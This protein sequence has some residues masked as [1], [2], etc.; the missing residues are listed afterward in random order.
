MLSQCY[1]RVVSML[2]PFINMFSTLEHVSTCCQHAVNML[3]RDHAE[4]SFEHVYQHA[5]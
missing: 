3:V 5:V 2:Q 4:I 1:Q